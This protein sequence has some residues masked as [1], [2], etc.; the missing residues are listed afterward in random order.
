MGML[1]EV[2]RMKPKTES[3]EATNHVSRHRRKAEGDRIT[4][5]QSQAPQVPQK[6]LS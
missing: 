3:Q 4:K 5:G 6:T 1:P 2:Q